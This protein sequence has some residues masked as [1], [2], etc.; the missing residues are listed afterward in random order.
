MSCNRR[1]STSMLSGVSEEGRGRGR[2]GRG[3]KEE[4]GG[5]RREGGASLHPGHMDGTSYTLESAPIVVVGLHETF[6]EYNVDEILGR[7]VIDA[8]DLELLADALVF[9]EDLLARLVLAEVL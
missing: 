7:L 3:R 2:S 8:P 4:E 9:A 6:G 5:G 1:D